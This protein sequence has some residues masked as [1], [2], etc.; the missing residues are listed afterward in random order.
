M[1]R[2][3][4]KVFFKCRDCNEYRKHVLVIGDNVILAIDRVKKYIN[5]KKAE[6]ESCACNIEKKPSEKWEL[7]SIDMIYEDIIV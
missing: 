7:I 5:T 3:I 2:K 6:Y 4:Y 1:K